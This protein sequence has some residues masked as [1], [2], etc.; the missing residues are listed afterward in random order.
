MVL[1]LARDTLAEPQCGQCAPSGQR[2]FYK[3]LF[4][5]RIDRKHLKQLFQADAFAM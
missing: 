3:P 5:G 4:S 2:L 1:C